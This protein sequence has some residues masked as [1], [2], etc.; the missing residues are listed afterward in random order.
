MKPTK[1]KDFNEWMQY[2]IFEAH[3]RESAVKS[4]SDRIRTPHKSNLTFNNNQK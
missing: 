1:P 4:T 3:K 2:I